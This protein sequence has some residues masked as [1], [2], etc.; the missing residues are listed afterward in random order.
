MQL[1]SQMS[2]L[3]L[4]LNASFFLSLSHCWFQLWLSSVKWTNQTFCDILW[5]FFNIWTRGAKWLKIHQTLIWIFY[6]NLLH[7]RRLYFMAN[8]LSSFHNPLLILETTVA[9]I[10]LLMIFKTQKNVTKYVLLHRKKFQYTTKQRCN[11]FIGLWFNHGVGSTSLL[12]VSF[13]HLSFHASY[14][15]NAYLSYTFKFLKIPWN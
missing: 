12:G 1:L 7:I 3:F 5:S 15:L 6:K 10:V 13:C 2:N 11:C 14:L 8:F 4:F 9:H